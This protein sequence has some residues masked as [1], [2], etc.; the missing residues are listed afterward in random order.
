VALPVCGRAHPHLRA[1]AAV[2]PDRTT[3]ELAYLQARFAGLISYGMSAKLLGELLP[4]GRRLHPTVVRRWTHTVAQRLEN[5]LGDER[6]SYITPAS[7]TARNC[8]A[9]T[10]RWSWA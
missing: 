3:P 8:R 4:L 2:L 7:L 10:C 9:Q 1:L 5:E 6:W